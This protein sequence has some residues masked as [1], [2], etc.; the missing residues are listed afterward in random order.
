MTSE[1]ELGFAVTARP[2]TKTGLNFT[3]TTVTAMG[4]A[5]V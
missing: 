3:S 5:N 2:E 1:T 4:V